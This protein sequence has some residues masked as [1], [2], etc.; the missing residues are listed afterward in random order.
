MNGLELRKINEVVVMGIKGWS[1]DTNH[2]YE[3]FIEAKYPTV[4]RT[5]YYEDLEISTAN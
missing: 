4:S 2:D 5:S 3:C 1:L